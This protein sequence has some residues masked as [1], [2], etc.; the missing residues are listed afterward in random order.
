MELM[1][2][3]AKVFDV[4]VDFLIRNEKEVAINKIRNQE[5]L[6][7]LEELNN[8]PVKDQETVV[9]FLDVFL[10]AESSRNLFMADSQKKE[11]RR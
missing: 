10:S 11:V 3:I 9:S 8:M 6:H 4:S 1:L 7:Q 2:R 5:L